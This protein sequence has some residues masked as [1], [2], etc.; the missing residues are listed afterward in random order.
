MNL[1][2]N[3]SCCRCGAWVE[4][5]GDEFQWYLMENGEEVEVTDG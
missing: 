5:Q 4:V 1:K 2:L 3:R